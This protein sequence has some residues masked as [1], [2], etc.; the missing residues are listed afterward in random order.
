MIR[1]SAEKTATGIQRLRVRLRRAAM[2]PALARTTRWVRLTTDARAAVFAAGSAIRANASEVSDKGF[3]FFMEQP[4]GEC[5]E[6]GVA[7]SLAS[8]PP[9]HDTNEILRLIAVHALPRRSLRGKVLRKN[10]G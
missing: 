3:S 5:E 7:P 4:P 1:R 10:E 9:T 6:R 8:G 2:A